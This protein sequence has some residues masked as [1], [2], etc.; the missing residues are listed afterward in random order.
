MVVRMLRVYLLLSNAENRSACSRLILLLRLVTPLVLSM[1]CLVSA[2]LVTVITLPVS[3]V[4]WWKPGLTD[5][6][7]V[8]PGQC[9]WVIPVMRVD[10][11]FTWVRLV[12]T[13]RVVIR[14]CSLLVIGVRWVRT[15]K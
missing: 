8:R 12:I 15:L 10:R 7:I 9:T 4:T 11:L 3:L 13:C 5:L 14:A 2:C 6:G 1:P